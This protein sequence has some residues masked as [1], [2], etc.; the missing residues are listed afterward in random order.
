MPDILWPLE[1]HTTFM[2][3]PINRFKTTGEFSRSGWVPME[4]IEQFVASDRTDYHTDQIKKGALRPM[5]TRGQIAVDEGSRKR[6]GTYPPGTRIR[7]Q[8]QRPVWLTEESDGRDHSPV[9]VR[10]P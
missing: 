1:P 8:H 6:K 2:Y 4:Q 7:F 5:E 10:G 9:P 3:E